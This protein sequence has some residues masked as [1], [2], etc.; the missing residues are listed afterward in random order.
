M[1]CDCVVW[2][3]VLDIVAF[4]SPFCVVSFLLM[5]LF[6]LLLIVHYIVDGVVS[7]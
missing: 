6:H 7:L 1:C 4:S 5:V 2:R 3:L